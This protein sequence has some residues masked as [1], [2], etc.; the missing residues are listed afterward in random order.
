MGR[1]G[2]RHLTMVELER[3]RRRG[4]ALLASGCSQAETARRLGVRAATVS[5]WAARPSP[6]AN[7]RGPRPGSG[8]LGGTHGL[9]V[10]R[11]VLSEAADERMWTPV[12]VAAAL[13]TVLHRRPSRWTVTGLLRRFGLPPPRML[14][15]SADRSGAGSGR[16]RVS[17]WAGM[18]VPIPPLGWLLAAANGRGE[19]CFLVR[20]RRPDA[21]AARALLAGLRAE[22]RVPLRLVLAGL[23]GPPRS[24]DLPAGDRLELVRGVGARRLPD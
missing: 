10:L 3:L 19:R 24:W 21:V 14:L 12:Q 2:A 20:R 4:L 15:Q 17:L 5:A 16:Q 11:R 1:A 18:A 6:A 8:R 23:A 22:L 7:P 13:S 9:A